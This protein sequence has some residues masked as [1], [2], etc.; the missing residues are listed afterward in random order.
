MY[1]KKYLRSVPSVR[2][3]VHTFSVEGTCMHSPGS[4]LNFKNMHRDIKIITLLNTP[5]HSTPTYSP[6]ELDV[7]DHDGHTFRMNG[8]QIS[9]KKEQ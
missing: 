9:G 6:G 5:L 1:K 7:L 3:Y 2:L 4:V 8:T